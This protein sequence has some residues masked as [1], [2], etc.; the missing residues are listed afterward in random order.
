[1]SVFLDLPVGLKEKLWSHLLQ[2][3]IEQVAI[4]FAAVAGRGR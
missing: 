4:I 3:D 1:M 2:N